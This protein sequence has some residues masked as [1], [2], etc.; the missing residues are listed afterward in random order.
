L[1]G[2]IMAGELPNPPGVD[3]SSLFDVSGSNTPTPKLQNQLPTGFTSPTF[4]RDFVP[5]ATDDSTTFATGSKDTL[6]IGGG[7]WQCKGSNNVTD[8]G[9]ILNAYATAFNDTNGDLIIYFALEISSNEGTKDVGFWFLKSNAS[10][11]PAKNAQDFTGDH[12]DGDILVVSEYTQG[13]GVS[14]IK[15]FRWDGG[16]N[17][18]LNTPPFLTG[19]DCQSISGGDQICATVNKTGSPG[20]LLAA[21]GQVPWL[22]Q[23]KTSKP[24][25]PNLTS[26]D[27]DVGEFFEGGID[28]TAG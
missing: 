21:S 16:A 28:L 15:A 14:T 2:S 17:G 19:N 6:N 1:D 8:K 25:I 13:G 24:S 3:W 12:Q 27:L 22:T 9:D 10:C 11:T 5:G 20:P 4:V 26:A 23:T 18:S 7:G